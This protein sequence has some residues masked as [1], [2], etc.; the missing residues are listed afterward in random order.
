MGVRGRL[1]CPRPTRSERRRTAPRCSRGS[2]GPQTSPR[3]GVPGAPQ[4]SVLP[5]VLPQFAPVC[6]SAPTPRSIPVRLWGVP[7]L[8]A[9]CASGP[10]VCAHVCNARGPCAYVCPCHVR[11]CAFVCVHVRVT[12]VPYSRAN[13]YG[14]P[15]GHTQRVHCARAC[16]RIAPRASACPRA[17]GWGR[18]RREGRCRGG[19]AAAPLSSAQSRTVSAPPRRARAGGGAGLSGIGGSGRTAPWALRPPAGPRCCCGLCWLCCC[20]P[21][22]DGP[23]APTP[24]P[25]AAPARPQLCPR[26]AATG[27]AAERGRPRSPPALPAAPGTAAAAA[28]ARGGPAAPGAAGRAAAPA[29]AAVHEAMEAPG[30]PSAPRVTQTAGVRTAPGA[31]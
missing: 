12:R 25:A 8:C 2:L 16:T 27:T 10:C 13:T 28:G 11:G 14:R 5:A 7:Q 29:A 17:R 1:R 31:Q 20:W 19:G 21:R 9:R 15:C 26:N 24:I 3:P 23:A 18:C 4:R 6:P 30:A 22:R